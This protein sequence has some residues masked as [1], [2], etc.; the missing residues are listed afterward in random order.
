[1][2]KEGLLWPQA[3]TKPSPMGKLRLG[4]RMIITGWSHDTG[5]NVFHMVH[6]CV[7]RV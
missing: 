4:G 1:M 6:I 3:L 2:G 7:Y 5:D